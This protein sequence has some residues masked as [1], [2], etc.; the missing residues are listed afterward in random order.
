VTENRTSGDSL[1]F[2]QSSDCSQTEVSDDYQKDEQNKCWD[3]SPD[4]NE[5]AEDTN[6]QTVEQ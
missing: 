5:D 2:L 3:K 4:V 1:D 6:G